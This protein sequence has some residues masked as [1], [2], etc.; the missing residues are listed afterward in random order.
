MSSRSI[1]TVHATITLERPLDA[2]PRHVV[3]HVECCSASFVDDEPVGFAFPKGTFADPREMIRAIAESI[4]VPPA[5][6]TITIEEH[7]DGAISVMIQKRGDENAVAF[8]LENEERV[9]QR[10]DLARALVEFEVL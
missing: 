2:R 10:R 5:M 9:W 4:V 8:R 6:R 7:D 1:E 3:K